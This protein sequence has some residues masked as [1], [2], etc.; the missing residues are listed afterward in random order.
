MEPEKE[1]R[2]RKEL[3]PMR[4]IVNTVIGQ[5]VQILESY[6]D[7]CKREIA[8]ILKEQ[9]KCKACCSKDCTL[10]IPYYVRL[11]EGF[12]G[13][14]SVAVMPC[15]RHKSAPKEAMKNV[16]ELDAGLPPLYKDSTFEDFQV[17][18]QNSKAVQ[19]AKEFATAG[20]PMLGIY[21]TGPKGTGKTMLA[22]IAA[23]EKVRQGESVLFIDMG[24]L[25][26]T[27]E[28][29]SKEKI[30]KIYN[31]LKEAPLLVLDDLGV[32]PFTEAI[33][34]QFSRVVNYRYSKDLPMLVTSC[35]TMGELEKALNPYG[36]PKEKQTTATKRLISRLAAM[37][38]I[39]YMHGKDRRIIDQMERLNT[40]LF[41]C[42]G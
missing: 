13:H 28:N 24:E 10:F 34:I 2:P 17:T 7:S 42:Q 14:Y 38:N 20:K 8:D 37:N 15:P 3:P 39:A 40:G 35:Y 16:M 6:Y 29:S 18:P 4:V 41:G 9:E 32:E 21:F 12:G 11:I 36:V 5:K 23:G 30:Q 1:E 19:F 25:L 31:A 27:L 22:C 33:A 26:S